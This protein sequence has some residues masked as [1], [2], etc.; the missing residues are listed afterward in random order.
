MPEILRM[1]EV[2]ANTA[3]AI[4]ASWNVELKAPYRAGD[5]IAAIETD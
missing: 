5:V 1:P 3:E 2:A 4:L